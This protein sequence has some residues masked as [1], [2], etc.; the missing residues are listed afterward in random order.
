[1][2]TFEVSFTYT[3]VCICIHLRLSLH[4]HVWACVCIWGFLYVHTC[5]HMCIFEASFTYTRVCICIH[6]RL[7]LHTH[8]WA[9]VCIWGSL[10][11]HTCVH[12]CTFEAS[13]T[14]TWVCICLH[15][16]ILRAGLNWQCQ[17][18]APRNTHTHAHTSTH[19][20]IHRCQD[21]GWCFSYT[22]LKRLM[23]FWSIISMHQD[24]TI[25]FSGSNPLNLRFSLLDPSPQLVTIIKIFYPKSSRL[26]VRMSASLWEC[27]FMYF[28]MRVNGCICMFM[29][30]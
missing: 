9:Y 13:F 3:R 7:S 16:V 22:C 4:T 1:M 21:H 20:H 28:Y 29:Y 23:T 6:L 27:L 15:V 24:Y 17:I 8:V 30:V 25:H 10:Y 12:M 26:L 14:Y 2:C 5:V 19:M 18:H 11:V